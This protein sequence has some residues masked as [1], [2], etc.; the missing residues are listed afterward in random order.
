MWTHYYLGNFGRAVDVCEAAIEVATKLDVP[1]VMYPTI[2]TFALL[3]QGRYQE[4]HESLKSE[5]ADEAHPFGR[6]FRD[7]G[8]AMWLL[9]VGAYRQAAAL[10]EELVVRVDRLRRGW[11]REWVRLLFVRSVLLI[12][13]PSDSEW[14]RAAQAL[15][16]AE[17]SALQGLPQL[18]A[19]RLRL[20][21]EMA[22]VEDWPDEALLQIVEAC[23]LLADNCYQGDLASAMELQARILLRLQR[24]NE[25]LALCDE[26]LTTA[27]EIGQLPTIW[28]LHA[29]KAQV[30]EG[31]GEGEA[32]RRERQSARAIIQKL[33]ANIQ[34]SEVRAG[35]LADPLI[36]SI[37]NADQDQPPL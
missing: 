31:L 21:A 13:Q 24:S 35:Y 6:T 37:L 2:K 28:R 1:P 5:I 8:F 34:E 27:T 16:D 3:G 26:A 33:A 29:T 17:K 30:L 20:Q 32:A 18:E 9:E 22:L 11:L 19:L 15:A 7:V 36:A 23:T 12:E 14:A 4:A 25:A 10:F